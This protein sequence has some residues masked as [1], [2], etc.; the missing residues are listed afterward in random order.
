[1]L[2]LNGFPPP[3]LDCCQFTLLGPSVR[4]Y[5][6]TNFDVC[7]RAAFQEGLEGGGGAGDA[8][9]AG[10]DS[11]ESFDPVQPLDE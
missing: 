4:E 8:G 5:L 11:Q 3:L 2:L 9:D 7:L 10:G 1:M 6:E